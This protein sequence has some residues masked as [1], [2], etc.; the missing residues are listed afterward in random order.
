M[1]DKVLTV[2]PG[3]KGVPHLGQVVYESSETE[4]RQGEG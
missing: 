1:S 2:A 3:R 4:G